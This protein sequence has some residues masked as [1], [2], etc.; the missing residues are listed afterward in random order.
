[1]HNNILGSRSRNNFIIVARFKIKVLRSSEELLLLTASN[2]L[3]FWAM[4]C[5]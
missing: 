3:W 1:M 5:T 4:I 2:N